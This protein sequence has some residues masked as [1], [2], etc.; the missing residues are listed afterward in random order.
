MKNIYQII[1]TNNNKQIDYIGSY[2]TM[3]SAMQSFYNIYTSNN[4]NIIFP[5]KYI[6]IGRKIQESNYEL[7]LIKYK[8]D[9]DDDIT[10]LR[11]N[12]GAYTEYITN[13]DKWVICDKAPF[14]KEETFWVYG[15]HPLV[16]RKDF[17][18]IFNTYIKPYASHKDSFISLSVFKNKL[19]IEMSNQLNMVICKNKSDS[20]RLY[21]MI[22][23]YCDEQKL[24]YISFIGDANSTKYMRTQTIDKIQKL[25]NWN[26]LK[27]NRSTTRP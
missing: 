3:D 16:Q 26:S 5:I 17:S 23:T 1:L 8:D 20:I 10:L 22:E 13:N 15:F 7:V 14:F 9:N 24:K 25:T 4:N 12:F 18:F 21:N 27:I 2:Q 19:L 6:N 11:N